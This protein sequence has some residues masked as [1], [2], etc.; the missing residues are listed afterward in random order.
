M[1]FTN[2]AAEHDPVRRSSV[3]VPVRGAFPI[4][5]HWMVEPVEAVQRSHWSPGAWRACISALTVVDADHD[6][7]ALSDL[8]SFSRQHDLPVLPACSS[9]AQ[10]GAC[11][12]QAEPQGRRVVNSGWVLEESLDIEWAHA[13][14]PG[15]KIVLV[16]AADNSLCNLFGAVGWANEQ[17][18]TQVSLSWDTSTFAGEMSDDSA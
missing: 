7:H 6:S 1:Q 15:A 17:G 13:E 4:S 9:L 5:G 16:E 2:R 8:D 14:A 10:T 12:V 11:F 18:A 3:E